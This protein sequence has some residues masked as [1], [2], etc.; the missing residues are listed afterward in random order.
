MVP[1]RNSEPR[2]A[3]PVSFGSSQHSP[4]NSLA[5]VCPTGGCS[6]LTPAGFAVCGQPLSRDVSRLTMYTVHPSVELNAKFAARP[7]QG[8]E[9]RSA[10]FLFIGLDANYAADIEQSSIFGR[11]LE[12][13]EDGARFWIRH[14]VHHPFLLPGYSGDGR[15]YHRTFAQIGFGP[16]HASLVSFAE[17]LHVPTV[18]RS[19]LTPADL[20]SS[21]LQRLNDAVLGGSPKNTFVSVGVARLMHA[22][23]AFSWLQRD[24]PSGKV[25]PAI[26][27]SANGTVF[28]HLHFSNYGKFQ[29]QL[30]AEARAI[31]SLLREDG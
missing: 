14:R 9:P 3:T 23:G 15:R 20:D 7:F 1:R 30:N 27:R 29:A 2:P 18:G 5:T 11:I 13:H 31:S 26:H 17:L 19:K 6:G 24:L 22:S 21:H 16:Q 12:Y 10:A 4:T 8:V 28:L 25:L